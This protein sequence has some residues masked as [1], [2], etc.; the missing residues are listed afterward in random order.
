MPN[1]N[2]KYKITC[3]KRFQNCMGHT[4]NGS[5]FEESLEYILMLKAN[6]PKK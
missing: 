1:K 5:S 3:D 6:K 4:T 2:K